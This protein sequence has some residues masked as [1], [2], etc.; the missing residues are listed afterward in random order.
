MLSPKGYYPSND[1]HGPVLLASYTW[2]HDAEL[3]LSMSNAEIIERVKSLLILEKVI[4]YV[5]AILTNYYNYDYFKHMEGTFFI[6]PL[7]P[8]L[9]RFFHDFWVYE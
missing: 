9:E 1:N 5:Q 8:K 3:F 6:G 4:L 2:E 7:T